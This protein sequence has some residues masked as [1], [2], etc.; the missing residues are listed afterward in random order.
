MKDHPF[1]FAREFADFFR[2]SG[3]SEAVEQ[4]GE[5][6]IRSIEHALVGAQGLEPRTPSV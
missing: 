2:V 6:L 5:C 1:E 3:I 4:I